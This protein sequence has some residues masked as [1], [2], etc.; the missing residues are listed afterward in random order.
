MIPYSSP[1]LNTKQQ[2][3]PGNASIQTSPVFL[4]VQCLAGYREKTLDI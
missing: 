2:H 4:K 1:N 3:L